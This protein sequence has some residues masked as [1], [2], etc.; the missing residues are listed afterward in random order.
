MGQRGIIHPGGRETVDELAKVQCCAFSSACGWMGLAGRNGRVCG[1]LLG[2]SDRRSVMDR[3]ATLWGEGWQPAEWAPQ[4]VSR[5]QAYLQGAVDP[6]SDVELDLPDSTLF[7]QAVRSAVRSIPYGQTASYAEIARRAGS[8]R[9]ARGVGGVMASNPIP[10]LIPCHRVV[11]SGGKLGGFSAP[12]GVDLKRWLLER[13]GC[14][15][16][17]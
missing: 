16:P 8:P 6:F 10:I 17:G 1:L 3:A 7:Q 14:T 13:E 5:L 9:A 11:A 2:Y 15:L 12:R 4:L